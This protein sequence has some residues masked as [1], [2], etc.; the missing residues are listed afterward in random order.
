MSQGPT[1]ETAQV[2]SQQDKTPSVWS[3]HRIAIHQDTKWPTHRC[4]FVWAVRGSEL[5]GAAMLPCPRRCEAIQMD[6]MPWHAMTAV[7]A[8]ASTPRAMDESWVRWWWSLDA[9]PTALSRLLIWPSLALAKA[10]TL[11]S[12]CGQ[13]GIVDSAMQDS[14]YEKGF[15]NPEANNSAYML[16]WYALESACWSLSHGVRSKRRARS[17]EDGVLDSRIK[18][19]CRHPNSLVVVGAWSLLPRRRFRFLERDAPSR[20]SVLLGS[21]TVSNHLELPPCIHAPLASIR[22]AQLAYVAVHILSAKSDQLWQISA[23][24]FCANRPHQEALS[25]NSRG[26]RQRKPFLA[27]PPIHHDVQFHA[28]S[29]FAVVVQQRVRIGGH[30]KLQAELGA[31]KLG[32]G[33]HGAAKEPGAEDRRLGLWRACQLAAQGNPLG[34]HSTPLASYLFSRCGMWTA[35]SGEQLVWRT[36]RLMVISVQFISSRPNQLVP[37]EAWGLTGKC[38]MRLKR[39]QQKG[40]QGHHLRNDS[41]LLIRSWAVRP[42]CLPSRIAPDSPLEWSTENLGFLSFSH[43]S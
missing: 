15:P 4:T 38:A 23:A 37:S 10:K 43:T 14:Q 25:F 26:P 20:S 41:V 9:H 18:G 35:A 32:A 36:E 7:A 12:V 8:A 21:I 30:L 2:H 6:A 39:S 34:Q 11:T 16:D 28:L 5:A 22:P 29:T 42:P 17:P 31:I 1:Q 3:P 24:S 40:T 33:I 27:D 19:Q 13:G